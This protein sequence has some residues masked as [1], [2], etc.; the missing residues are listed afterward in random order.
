MT[1]K[2]GVQMIDCPE[3]SHQW[4]HFFECG[5]R[6]SVDPVPPAGGEPE[7]VY[8]LSNKSLGTAWRM[9]DKEAYD[10]M[11]MVPVYERRELVD[12]AHV[13]RLQAEVEHWRNRS[14]RWKERVAELTNEGNALQSELTR[15]RELFV[16]LLPLHGYS[17]G[18]IVE[19]NEWMQAN[20]SA[21]ADKGQGEAREVAE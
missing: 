9:A 5:N 14:S 15:A 19:V 3:C 16:R 11:A 13:T 18:L 2:C 21:P 10:S 20:Q 1:D 17:M 12:R 8:M 4:D 7:V 6:P